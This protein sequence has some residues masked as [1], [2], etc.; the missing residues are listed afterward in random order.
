MLKPDGELI[1]KRLAQSMTGGW[2]I[3]SDN[4][5][6]RQYPDEAASD[7]EIGH[8]KIVGRIVWHGGAL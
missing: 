3:R 6:K 5:D 8:L 4:E 7:N 1:I 2:I